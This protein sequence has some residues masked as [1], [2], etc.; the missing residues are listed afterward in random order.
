MD[1]T[2][3]KLELLTVPEVAERVR[4]GTRVVVR[5]IAAGDLRASKVAGK[6]LV[7]PE[8]I[9]VYVDSQSNRPKLRRRTP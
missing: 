4:C 6:W 3:S 9:E 2:E 5:L 1:I 7:R 8:D